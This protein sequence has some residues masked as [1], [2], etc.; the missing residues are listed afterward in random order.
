MSILRFYS[1]SRSC[2]MLHLPVLLLF[3][4]MLAVKGFFALFTKHTLIV[5]CCI[6]LVAFLIRSIGLGQ[7][8]HGFHRDEVI[9][10][11]V[12]RFILENGK[13]IY[14]NAWPVLYVDKYGDYP[15]ALPMYLSGIGTYFF[16][17]TIFATRFPIAIVGSLI[18]FPMYFLAKLLFKNKT[19]GLIAALLTA[20][21][22]WH[23]VLSRATAEGI[24]AL[25]VCTFA[26]WLFLQS[27]L[28]KKRKIF[29]FSIALFL[30]TYLLYP[31]F[32]L[33]VPIILLPTPFLF[34][35]QKLPI[36]YL[37]IA[38]V[39]S[40]LCTAIIASTA[41]GKGRY[42]QTSIFGN[43]REPSLASKIDHFA[44][45]EGTNNVFIARLF[46]N[47]PIVYTR[48][49]LS[50]Y[51][52]YFTPAYLFLTGGFPER[53]RV[54]EQGLLYT[55]MV[56]L[57]LSAFYGLVVTKDKRLLLYVLYLLIISPIPSPLTFD[58]APN[59]HRSIFMIIP[60]VLLAAYGAHFLVVNIHKKP[61][62]F[63]VVGV[64]V[65]CILVEFSYFLHQ[66]F[67]HTATYQ[68][69]ARGEA[70][71]ETIQFLLAKKDEYEKAIAPVHD[72]F[73]I[74][75]LFFSQDLNSEHAGTFGPYLRKKSIGNVTFVDEACPRLKEEPSYNVLIVESPE[76]THGPELKFVEEIHRKDG[77]IVYRFLSE[78]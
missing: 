20:I 7:I 73:P 67:N 72:A 76:C 15:P 50:Q 22:P 51:G 52:S 60:L 71:V 55:T 48:E 23:I 53:Y 4:T 75:Y 24:V 39:F 54:P 8:P 34:A 11:Y 38:L 32:R 77:S 3:V 13:D 37:A 59:V 21:L 35:K 1:V 18:I 17:M 2:V 31:S 28:E 27:I 46:H 70:N 69:R 78:K 45:E 5:L 64:I 19:I 65:L 16:G 12:G 47:K 25:T 49:V 66:Y 6:F 56:I 40:I 63:A 33:L 10:G 43:S 36:R 29:V 26:L 62:R 41:W 9:S 30:F 61:H 42:E 58:D 44:K 74:Y 57:L 68:G 14:N